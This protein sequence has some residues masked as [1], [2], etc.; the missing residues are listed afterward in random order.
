[1]EVLS[2]ADGIREERT[3]LH[4]V[5]FIETRRHWFSSPVTHH[6]EGSVHVLN[7]VEGERIVVTSPDGRFEPF[8]AGYAE[9][10]IVPAGV[11]SYVVAPL[12]PDRPHA[13]IRAS[14]RI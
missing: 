9:T 2:D 14:V 6:T 4:A 11:G 12:D 7:L 1:V 5:E 13:T 8:E 3:G 10:F